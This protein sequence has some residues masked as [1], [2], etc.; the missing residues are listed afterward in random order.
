[1]RSNLDEKGNTKSEPS[2]ITFPSP[3]LLFVYVSSFGWRIFVFDDVMTSNMMCVGFF[4]LCVCVCVFVSLF[5]ISIT[6][7]PSLSHTPY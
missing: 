6:F 1:M 3:L 5:R 7:P 2:H 4:S